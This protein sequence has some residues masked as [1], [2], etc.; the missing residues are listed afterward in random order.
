M[1]T[2]NIIRLTDEAK[3]SSITTQNT[4]G[5]AQTDSRNI[6]LRSDKQLNVNCD[7]DSNPEATCEWLVDNEVL[8]GNCNA[9]LDLSSSSIVK[10]KAKNSQY[11]NEV[12]EE[13][14][15]VTIVNSKRKIK[16]VFIML[17][18]VLLLFSI[19]YITFFCVC[20]SVEYFYFLNLLLSNY[21]NNV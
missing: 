7:V 12:V 1:F 9:Q 6:Y 18:T 21:Y 20:F 5:V 10:C 15:N 8:E 16:I 4:Q 14:L 2:L 19:R 11:E 13:S 3:I 17:R